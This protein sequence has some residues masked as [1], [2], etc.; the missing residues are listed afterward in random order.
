MNLPKPSFV[1]YCKNWLI[2]KSN[3]GS[4]NPIFQIE[5]KTISKEVIPCPACIALLDH[6]PSESDLDSVGV[7]IG[8]WSDRDDESDYR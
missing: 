1:T 8:E 5:A 4:K 3:P 2:S 7:L 6:V